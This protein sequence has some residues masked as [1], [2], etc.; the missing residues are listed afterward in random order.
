MNPQERMAALERLPFENIGSSERGAHRFWAQ[1]R[2]IL[3][4]RAMLLLFVKRD[5]KSRYKDSALGFFWTLVR[6]ITQLLIY[7]VVLG[8]FLGAER[9]IP[10]FAIYIFSGLTIYGLFSEM[11]MGGTAS[12]IANAGLV[13]KV[14]LPRELFP[15]ATIG[16]ALFNF[17]IQLVILLVA[18]LAMGSFPWTPNMVYAIPSL[19]VILLYG[20]ALALLLSAVNVYLRDV[21]YL[22]EVV[23]MVLMWASPI[24]YAWKYVRN[25]LGDGILL[26]IYNSNPVTMAVLGFQRAFW[27][28]GDPTNTSDPAMH[29][30]YPENLM[31]NLWIA[32]LIGAVGVF[33]A[34]RL[35]A[36][37]QGNFAQML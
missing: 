2:L 30:A 24:L 37:L 1:V 5:L 11:V 7:Y 36:R 34:Q 15:L 17:A 29:A 12:V 22:V 27:T 19:L 9:G 23:L 33:L 14:Y 26:S 13:K 31:M 10:E 4:N 28:A 3:K 25:V 20:T 16:S 6:P 35:F 8:K 21:Q 32:A 18:T